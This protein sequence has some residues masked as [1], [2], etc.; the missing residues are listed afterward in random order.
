M[1]KALGTLRAVW[2]PSAMV[3]SF[4]LETDEAL[5]ADKVGVERGGV[6][7][8]EVEVG[9]RPR[10]GSALPFSGGGL[11]PPSCWPSPL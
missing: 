3:A 7:G 4:K 5:L 2:A 10:W 11:P 6:C 8:G 1:P 9:A